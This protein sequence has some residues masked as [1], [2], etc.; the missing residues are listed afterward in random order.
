MAART[1]LPFKS[2]VPVT[3]TPTEVQPAPKHG[4]A[5]IVSDTLIPYND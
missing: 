3:A 1:T 5:A 2:A 4:E